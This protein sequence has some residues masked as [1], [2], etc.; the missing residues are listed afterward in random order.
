VLI[1][2]PEAKIKAMAAG[3]IGLDLV[4]EAKSG[5]TGA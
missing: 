1:G 3:Y 4:A 5:G 2:I